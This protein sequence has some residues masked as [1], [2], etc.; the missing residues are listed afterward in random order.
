[1]QH[2]PVM[3]VPPA[4]KLL[5]TIWQS[6]ATLHQVLESRGVSPRAVTCL[7]Q[8]ARICNVGSTMPCCGCHE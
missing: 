4:I 5:C 2:L 7:P 8:K 3:H 1:M 6:F